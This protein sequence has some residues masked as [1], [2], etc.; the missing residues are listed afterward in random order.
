MKM[1]GRMKGRPGQ[2]EMK[3]QKEIKAKASG[4]TLFHRCYRGH[5]PMAT[6]LAAW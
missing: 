5:F 3:G 1:Q 4:P 2:K 6:V